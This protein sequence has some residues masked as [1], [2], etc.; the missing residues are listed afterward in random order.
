MK[1]GMFCIFDY[2]PE[3]GSVQEYHRRFAELV[4]VSED[5]GFES[6]WVSEH[7][8][9][10]Y[11]GILPRPQL[12]LASL[13]SLTSRVRLGSAVSLVPLDNPIRMAEDYALLD[14]ISGGRVNF[15]AGRG[16]FPFEYDGFGISQD[17]SRLR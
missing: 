16:L 2:W 8:F 11:G 12:L 14:V 5:L 10:N 6:V 15:G 4:T 13:A 9:T 3:T 7:H 1:F 17:E